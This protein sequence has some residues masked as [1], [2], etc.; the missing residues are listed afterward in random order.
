MNGVIGAT[1]IVMIVIICIQT[2]AR[3]ASYS[4]PWSE[5]LSRYLFCFV[6]ILGISVGIGEN[7][8]IRMDLLDNKLKPNAAFVMLM[9]RDVIMIFICALTF[10]YSFNLI[11]L[12]TFRKSPS[13][14]IPMHYVYL[15]VPVGFGI[16]TFCAII[17]TVEDVAKHAV[18]EDAH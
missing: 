11:K 4:V 12:G 6:I 8:F 14:Q 17:R 10:I 5:E 9:I 7:S 16:A 1:T 3:V 13:M 2:I 18:K 15:V